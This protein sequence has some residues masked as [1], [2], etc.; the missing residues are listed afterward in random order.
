MEEQQNFVKEWPLVRLK[1]LTLEEYT[2]LD[3]ETSLV[4]WL[5]FRTSN[6][7]GIGG[8]SAYKFGIFKQKN[9]VNGQSGKRYSTDGEYSWSSKYGSTR[10]EAF[11][12]VKDILIVTAEASVSNDLSS[13]D[14]FDI[15]D[16]I[17]WKL[18]YLYSPEYI[19]PI[20]KKDILERAAQ[21]NG[22]SSFSSTKTSE[23]QQF[24]LEKKPVNINTLEYAKSLWSEF[25]S[26]NFYFVIHKFLEQ[27]ETD[28]LKKVGYP[29]RY[30]DL[31]VKV[32]FGAGNQARVPW[33]GFLNTSNKISNGIYPVYLFFK[34]VNHLVLAYGI[35]DTNPPATVW[36]NQHNL[37]PIKDWY[38]DQF[39]KK[40]ERYGGSYVMASYNLN[41]ELSL[42][43][44]EK[45]LDKIIGEYKQ[46]SS[47]EVSEPNDTQYLRSE[48]KYWLIS[49]GQG[50]SQWD[51]F[52]DKSYIA[53]GWDKIS[54]LEN[55]SDKE[56]I[57][58]KLLATYPEEETSHKNGALALWEFLNVLKTGDIIIPKKGHKKYLGYGI[59]ESDYY[60]E[61]EH[62]SFKH[63][64]KV[65]W[66]K[67]GVWPEEAGQIVTKTFT[68]IT[69]YPEYVD[70]LKRLIGIGQDAQIPKAVNHWWLNASPKF[71]KIT[72]FEIGEEQSY[73]S[74]NEQGNKRSKFEYFKSVKPGDLMIGYES[75]PVKKVVAILEITKGAHVDEDD[76][77]EKISFIIQQFLTR[78]LSWG[79]LKEL[80]KFSS[81]EVL[82]SNQ[83][84]LFKLSADEF[85]AIIEANIVVQ[86]ESYSKEKALNE[87]F[88]SENELDNITNNLLYKNNIILQGPPGTGKTFLAKRLAY[89]M[90]EQKDETRTDI[91]Q[92]HQSYSYED[93]IQGFRPQPDGTFKL[94]NGVF[95]RF[96]KK[97]A[98][99][100]NNDY[101]FIID[102]I[103]RGNLSK[104]FGE[105]MLLIEKDKREKTY[106]VSLT[107]SQSS[108]TKFHIPKN[109]YIIGTMNTADRS[110]ALV[111]YALRRR[112]AF[113]EIM[114]S[115][116][117]KLSNHLIDNG[118]DEVVV[119]KIVSRISRL[120]K[121]ISSDRNLGPGFQI[122]HSYFCPS[123]LGAEKD[124]ASWYESV[125]KYEIIP[126]LH[127][128]WFDN[129][130]EVK[131]WE[132]QLLE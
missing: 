53:L 35:S 33:I 16:M 49:P 82:K 50:A 27:A 21:Y 124:F 86:N 75:S 38:I 6:A 118:V 112:F 74:H 11:K 66:V 18:A 45:D 87:I 26:D 56:E 39:G 64:R 44:I 30:K 36:P 79:Q 106:A 9:E 107:Y 40:P 102:E 78:Q 108:D 67:K 7:G 91:V 3:R 4:Y 42:E 88:I 99:D 104:I 85:K 130:E 70:R 127:E 12:C 131:R 101:F 113:I 122:G 41:E 92:F 105:L 5:E 63:R 80:E 93:F 48:K 125:I 68:D 10:E 89:L 43:L 61:Q 25:G 119:N 132:V 17:K 115:I 76:G 121:D 98:R 103:N 13:I 114:P 57:R 95:Y 129:I 32:S 15:G 59:V 97:A 81:A 60:F 23:L 117:E 14:K 8:G 100:P 72:D 1:N 111:D 110:L 128:Y 47:N 46:T 22:L 123:D 94:E 73:T 34:E 20:Y 58:Q 28:S 109:I 24:L 31:E 83:G 77:K 29:R 52:Y 19:L 84:S 71:W 126:L 55:F 51:D 96:C 62:N 90:I 54:N 2:N 69:K 37:I 120:N 65:K 116:S